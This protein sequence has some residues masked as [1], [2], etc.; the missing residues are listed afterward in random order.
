MPSIFAIANPKGGSGK[1]TAAII[2]AGEFAK[3]GYS[4]AIVDADPQGS[5]YQWYASSVARGLSPDGVDLVRASDEKALAQAID[6]LDAYDVVVVDTPGYYG[7]VL[8]SRRSGPTSSSCPARCTPSTPRR[9]FARSAISS[10][11]RPRRACP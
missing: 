5:S 4:T 3:Q 6:R 1:T 9:W 11:T 2:L 8:S 7:E 10:A